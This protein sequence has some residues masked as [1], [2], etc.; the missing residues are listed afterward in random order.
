MAKSTSISLKSSIKHFMDY[1]SSPRQ[2]NT[3]TLATE[4][5]VFDLIKSINTQSIAEDVTDFVIEFPSID[6]WSLSLVCDYNPFSSW[7]L[8]LHRE[9]I[10][11]R[12]CNKGLYKTKDG[13]RVFQSIPLPRHLVGFCIDILKQVGVQISVPLENEEFVYV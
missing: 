11:I 2:V 13:R 5:Q 6:G 10:D 1:P 12:M 4:Q 8:L 9:N 7:T 3:Y